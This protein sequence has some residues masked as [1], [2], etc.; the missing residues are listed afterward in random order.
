MVA[1]LLVDVT[2]AQWSFGGPA[3]V[4]LA[5]PLRLAETPT[6][7]GGVEPKHDDD[8][9]VDQ[10]GVTWRATMHDPNMIGLKVR[11]GPLPPSDETLTRYLQWRDG[12][13][14]GPQTGEFRV[15]GPRRETVQLWRPVGVP[16]AAKPDDILTYGASLEEEWQL[17][18]DESW[19][20]TNPYTRTLTAAQFAGATIANAADEDTWPY[21]EITGPISGPRIGLFGELIELP[22]IAA[23]QKWTIETDPNHFRILDHTGADR[24][25]WGGVSLPGRWYRKAPAGNLAIPLTITGTGTS[26]TTSVKVVLPQLY[27]SAL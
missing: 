9:N 3:Q 15:S 23:G 5:T 19:W 11:F 16:A 1:Y 17:R 4:S 25:Y 20:R 7:L 2:G 10:A 12:F 8:Q 18:S 26:A 21:Y 13:G 22:S 6:G 24:S 14:S 27:R